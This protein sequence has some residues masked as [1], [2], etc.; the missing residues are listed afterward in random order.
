MS[1]HTLNDVHDQLVMDKTLAFALDAPKDGEDEG[2]KKKKKKKDKGNATHVS[3]GSALNIS[4]FK[5]NDKFSLAWRCR[6]GSRFKQVT[7]CWVWPSKNRF[8]TFLVG[9]AWR[10]SLLL[11]NSFTHLMPWSNE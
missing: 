10:C 3:F 7:L 11:F 4:S 2:K 1:H 6:P 9:I 8:G 5:N